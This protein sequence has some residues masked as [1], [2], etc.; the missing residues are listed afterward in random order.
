MNIENFLQQKSVEAISALY[1]DVDSKLVQVQKTR[2]DFE[3]DFT[4]VVFPFLKTSRKGPEATAD[5]IGRYMTEHFAEIKSFNVV[6]GFLN[7]NLSHDFWIDC[8][9]DIV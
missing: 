1:G 6:K 2:K 4:L 8:F 7:I 5:E 9:N 3:G